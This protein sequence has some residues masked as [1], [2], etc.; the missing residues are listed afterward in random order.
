MI[1]FASE[2][3]SGGARIDSLC[4]LSID[5]KGKLKLA[6]MFRYDPKA[7]DGTFVKVG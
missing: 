7:G 4:E 5:S 2:D 1:A 3:E 6:E